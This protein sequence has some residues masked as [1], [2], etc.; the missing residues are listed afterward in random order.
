V[1]RGLTDTEYE[2]REEGDAGVER[3]SPGE[4]VVPETSTSR[5]DRGT[6]LRGDEST[7]GETTNGAEEEYPFDDDDGGD[8]AL[9]APSPYDDGNDEE[10]WEIIIEDGEEIRIPCGA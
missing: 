5:V 8:V 3:V 6:P 7:E 2:E 4:A 9:E 10:D 1:D